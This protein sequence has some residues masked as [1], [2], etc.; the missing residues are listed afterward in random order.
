VHN[1]TRGHLRARHLHLVYAE[2]QA[3][4]VGFFIGLVIGFCA[5]VV[6]YWNEVRK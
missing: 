2:G 6:W 5:G 1:S 3:L 4:I